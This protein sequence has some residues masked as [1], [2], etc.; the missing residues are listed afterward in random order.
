MGLGNQLVEVID[1]TV[2]RVDGGVVGN[3]ITVIHL[4]GNVERRQPDGV[5]TELL[6]V[7]KT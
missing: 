4:R 1:R 3:V 7:I 2:R 5:N 6:Q